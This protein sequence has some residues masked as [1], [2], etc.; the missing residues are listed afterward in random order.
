MESAHRR[1]KGWTADPVEY[2]KRR[3]KNQYINGSEV[4]SSDMR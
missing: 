1:V 2:S 4:A 3:N